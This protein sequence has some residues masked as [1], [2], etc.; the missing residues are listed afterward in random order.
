M[1]EKLDRAQPSH[2]N[3]AHSTRRGWFRQLTGSFSSL[4]PP[5]LLVLGGSTSQITTSPMLILLTN[6]FQD[7][8]S[9][10]ELRNPK[11]PKHFWRSKINS[12]PYLPICSFD[13]YVAIRNGDVP[14]Q[15]E[16]TIQ[17]CS[18]GTL[19]ALGV[20]LSWILT[21]FS[22]ARLKFKY[23]VGPSGFS[24]AQHSSRTFYHDVLSLTGPNCFG[25]KFHEDHSLARDTHGPCPGGSQQVSKE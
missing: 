3:R 17:Q 15:P 24:E 8:S 19:E 22:F 25:Y 7:D 11:R 10:E 23:S 18:H 9:Q 21:V 16:C 12:V 13:H 4:G 20:W 14:E 1:D 6:G 5:P 2:L